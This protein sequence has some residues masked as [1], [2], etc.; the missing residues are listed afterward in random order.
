VPKFVDA[1]EPRPTTPRGPKVTPAQM[2]DLE[3]YTMA[4]L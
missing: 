3:K 4:D 1:N 2:R